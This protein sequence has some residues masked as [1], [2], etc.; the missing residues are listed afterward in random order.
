MKEKKKIALLLC[1]AKEATAGDC[2]KDCVPLGRDWG[3][4]L[5]FGSEKQG[6][7]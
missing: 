2:L 1:Q 6:H 3:V 4:V 7:G 5:Q